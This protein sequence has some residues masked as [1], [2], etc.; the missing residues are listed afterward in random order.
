MMWIDDLFILIFEGLE[1]A[2]VPKGR[3]ATLI[4]IGTGDRDAR[5]WA[6]TAETRFLVR[7]E[8][9]FVV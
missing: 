2:V 6:S 5:Q 7:R 9:R 4:R 1:V 8:L 3:L